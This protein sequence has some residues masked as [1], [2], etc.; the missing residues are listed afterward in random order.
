MYNKNGVVLFD[1]RLQPKGTFKED[2]LYFYKDEYGGLRLFQHQDKI[3][4]FDANDRE[5]AT[6]DFEKVLVAESELYSI[7]GNALYVMN[8][9]QIPFV[10]EENETTEESDK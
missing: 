7:K 8:K 5:V 2:D 10:K 4:L 6:L 1:Q 9:A 3:V